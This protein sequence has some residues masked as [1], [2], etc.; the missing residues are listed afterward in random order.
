M[1]APNP[2]PLVSMVS[3]DILSGVHLKRHFIGSILITF[4]LL[5]SSPLFLANNAK[6]LPVRRAGVCTLCRNPA[7]PGP[8]SKCFRT[9][10]QSLPQPSSFHYQ[11]SQCWFCNPQARKLVEDSG[12]VCLF[13]YCRLIIAREVRGLTCISSNCCECQWASTRLRHGS[14]HFLCRGW[15]LGCRAICQT[16]SKFP[17]PVSSPFVVGP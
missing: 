6:L 14:K 9:P 17:H 1:P 4:L 7:H 16:L 11:G 2:T 3:Q 13:Y 10:R 8:L 12:C 15:G 5:S